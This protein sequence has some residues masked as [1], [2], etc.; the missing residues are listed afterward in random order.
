MIWLAALTS[1]SVGENIRG[2]KRGAWVWPRVEVILV[3]SNSSVHNHAENSTLF[4]F[5]SPKSNRKVCCRL[6]SCLSCAVAFPFLPFNPHSSPSKIRL[7]G[8]IVLLPRP[9]VSAIFPQPPILPYARIRPSSAT[10]QHS[11]LRLALVPLPRVVLQQLLDQV[12]V[13]HQHPPA[14]VPLAAQG[15]HCVSGRSNVS[16]S[17]CRLDLSWECERRMGKEG[18][19][20][21]PGEA[22][23]GKEVE[24]ERNRGERKQTNDAPVCDAGVQHVEVSLPKVA[25]HLLIRGR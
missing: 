22:R 7:L 18:R 5:Q 12:H 9:L 1:D 10:M 13:R 4:S 3:I 11:Q 8:I 19:L 24:L 6:G 15:V 2:K 21:T 25:Y 14:A 16:V 23:G 17:C 20:R